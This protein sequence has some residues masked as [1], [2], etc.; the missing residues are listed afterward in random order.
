[1]ERLR[2]HANLSRGLEPYYRGPSDGYPDEGDA[3]G[4]DECR[5][6][7]AV[8]GSGPRPICREFPPYPNVSPPTEQEEV[9]G[10]VT[11]G[12]PRR[13][14]RGERAEAA[15]AAAST[16]NPPEVA[17]ALSPPPPPQQRQQQQ[18]R[19]PPP[20]ATVTGSRA[21]ARVSD[22]HGTGVTAAAAEASVSV[23]LAAAA[24]TTSSGL[25]TTAVGRDG[26]VTEEPV[27]EG[28]EKDRAFRVASRRSLLARLAAAGTT[29][30]LSCRVACSTT[31]LPRRRSCSRVS[32]AAGDQK[33]EARAGRCRSNSCRG[34]GGGV[35]SRQLLALRDWDRLTRWRLPRPGGPWRSSTSWPVGRCRPV[36]SGAATSAA[37]SRAWGA[38]RLLLLLPRTAPHRASLR[39]LRWTPWPRWRWPR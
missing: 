7:Q 24:T 31:A 38:S 12:R 32:A 20:R 2:F 21:P 14:P 26:R 11:G 8:P 10:S 18:Q 19:P 3:E 17:T 33:A 1:M 9:R 29:P 16:V 6:C 27:E 15:A 35:D 39:S 36:G 30:S 28:W 25:T 5:S 37:D 4:S 13:A 34:G 23:S 22:S